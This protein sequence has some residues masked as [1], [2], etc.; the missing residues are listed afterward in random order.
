MSKITNIPNILRTIIFYGVAFG[1]FRMLV[2]GVS[3]LYLI[4]KGLNLTDIGLLKSFQFGLMMI[5]D[6]P[7][8]YIADRYSRKLST[9]LGVLFGSLWLLTTAFSSEIWQFYVAETFN[10]ISLSLFNGAYISYLIDTKNKLYKNIDNKT[11]LSYENKY[12]SLGM[13][14]CAFIGASFLKPTSNTI[15]IIAGVLLLI[16][17]AG[18][19]LQLPSDTQN[20]IHDRGKQKI[21]NNTLSIK[22]NVNHLLSII[23]EKIEIF[24]GILITSILLIYFQIILQLWQ[25]IIK[26]FNPSDL[27]WLYGMFFS[28]VSMAQLLSSYIVDKNIKNKHTY[29][30]VC[31]FISLIIMLL[32]NILFQQSIAGTLLIIISLFMMFFSIKFLMIEISARFHDIVP[33]NHRSFLDSMGFFISR[34]ILLLIFPIIT[35]LIQSVGFI[36]LPFI[37]LVLIVI[38]INQSSF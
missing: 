27:G 37:L 26:D 34:T 32:S 15:W 1:S 21:I 24:Y 36:S 18:S 12:N 11:I 29:I 13:A 33:N 38:Y 23:T 17:C 16:I 28:I 20:D 5:I 31:I 22:E 6:L 14:L 30:I 9:I 25:P 10:A 8:S 35:Y 2:G 4:G 19:F 3:V 7:L